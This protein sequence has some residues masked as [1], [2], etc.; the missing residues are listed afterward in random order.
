MAYDHDMMSYSAPEPTVEEMCAS[1]GHDVT[2][3]TDPDTGWQW[4]HCGS[5]T[6]P[7]EGEPHDEYTATVA[8]LIDAYVET[9]SSGIDSGNRYS[10]M[11][12]TTELRVHAHQALSSFTPQRLQLLVESIRNTNP[13][14][15]PYARRIEEELFDYFIELGVHLD[16][17]CRITV[18]TIVQDEAPHLSET[19]RVDPVL[20]ESNIELA[21]TA[22]RLIN[23]MGTSNYNMMNL[24]ELDGYLTVVCRAL[25]HHQE[26]IPVAARLYNER[27]VSKESTA[28][29]MEL[30]QQGSAPV[31]LAIVDGLL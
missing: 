10:D 26:F 7:V 2:V 6:A 25:E 31:Q 15:L 16:Y 13:A 18:S 29:I 12:N 28:H 5:S 27:G 23:L 1:T 22:A 19:A 3:Y 11:R 30:V 14:M 9:L 21:R 8:N 4:C 20:N 24:Y 17:Q